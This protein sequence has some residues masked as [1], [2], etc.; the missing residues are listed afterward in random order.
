[1]V[2]SLVEGGANVIGE[3]LAVGLL[4]EAWPGLFA[5]GDRAELAALLVR[6]EEDEGFRHSLTAEVERL[7]PDFEPALESA[8]WAELLAE[9]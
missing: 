9:L 7:R 3:A 6:F 8:A 2:P 1:V 5:P 4:G